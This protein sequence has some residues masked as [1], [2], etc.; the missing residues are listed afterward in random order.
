MPFITLSWGQN[1]RPP[2]SKD[3]W[4]Q[5]SCYVIYVRSRCHWIALSLIDFARHPCCLDGWRACNQHLSLSGKVEHPHPWFNLNIAMLGLFKAQRRWWW[6]ASAAPFQYA[7]SSIRVFLCC[8]LVVSYA[9]GRFTIAQCHLVQILCGLAGIAIT[10]ILILHS[11][12]DLR[13]A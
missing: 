10:F 6:A 3:P 2:R 1:R 11:R 9:L 4:K 8:L 13:V 5:E 7:S 12:G